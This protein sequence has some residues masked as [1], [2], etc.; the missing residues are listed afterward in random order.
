MRV[1]AQ[2]KQ[3]TRQQ[4]LMA[5]SNLLQNKGFDQTTTRDIAAAA[6]VAAG[7]VFNYFASKEALVIA[8]VAEALEK[9]AEE[10]ETRLRGDESLDEALFAHVAVGLRH[11]E[12]HRRYVGRVLEVALSP[13]ATSGACAQ[14]ELI[15]AE[16]LEAVGRL[17]ATRGGK[18][19]ASVSFVTMH[20]YWTLYLGV[21][22]FWSSDDSPRQEDTLVVLDQSMRMFAD[23]LAAS[24][25]LEE[26][27]TDVTGNR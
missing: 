27:V 21:L 8:L 18:N 24:R 14:A 17:I 9:A 6:G 11:L 7:T 4:I 3:E 13:M 26:E 23:S 10:F 20:L 16:Q 19:A 15:R 25:P 12:P 1:T 2:K 22:A 5:T